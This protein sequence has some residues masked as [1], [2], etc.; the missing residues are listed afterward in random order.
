MF[1]LFILL[2]QNFK[3]STACTL[4][5]LWKR[6]FFYFLY[7]WNNKWI[8]S[9]KKRNCRLEKNQISF[10]IFHSIQFIHGCWINSIDIHFINGTFQRQVISQM[11][12]FKDRSFRR[13]TSLTKYYQQKSLIHYKFYPNFNWSARRCQ[14]N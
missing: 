6:V 1:L 14:R 5:P 10:C 4:G 13:N 11:G 8:L 3:N 2:F 12:H 9:Q 7:D